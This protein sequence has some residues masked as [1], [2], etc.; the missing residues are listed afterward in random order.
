MKCHRCGGQFD[1][2]DAAIDTRN[3]AVRTPGRTPYTELVTMTICPG[4]VAGRAATRRFVFSTGV[5]LLAIICL[6]AVY[7]WLLR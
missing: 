6:A 1:S 5:V 4:C 2:R 7:Q 3:E